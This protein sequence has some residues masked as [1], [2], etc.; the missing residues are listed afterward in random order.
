MDHEMHEETP[1]P[2]SQPMQPLPQLQLLQLLADD[3]VRQ[4]DPLRDALS[5]AELHK[6][7]VGAHV[8]AGHEARVRRWGYPHVFEHW[9][10]HLTLA[11]PL[12]DADGV[13][14]A[15]AGRRHPLEQ[16]ARA[17]FSDALRAPLRCACTSKPR[18]AMRLSG[19][20][21]SVSGANFHDA[22]RRPGSWKT[23][24]LSH[25]GSG[26]TRRRPG[27]CKR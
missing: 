26:R 20:R 27:H 5:P 19:W 23:S 15:D 6:R 4:F 21:V 9:R 10:F 22:R 3:C 1:D 12:P 14:G 16:L 7:C 13:A 24:T 2:A 25:C 11:Q 17:H 18:R 8:D